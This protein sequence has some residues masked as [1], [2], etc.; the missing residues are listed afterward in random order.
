MT[1]PARMP[2]LARTEISTAMVRLFSEYYGR[3]PTRAR[4]Y[5]NDDIVAVV[6]EETFTRAEQTLVER[7]EVEAIQH[8]RRRFQQQMRDEFTAVVEQSTGRK[9]RAFLSQTSLDPDISVELFLL[10][11]EGASGTRA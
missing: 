10:A 2:G 8:V 7:G 9:V 5:I 6:L 3:G 11:E 1:E 4:T